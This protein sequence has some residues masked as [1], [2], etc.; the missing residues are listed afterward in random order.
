M[1]AKKNYKVLLQSAVF[2]RLHSNAVKFIVPIKTR[3]GSLQC[4][5]SSFKIGLQAYYS[6][7]NDNMNRIAVPT[8]AIRNSERKCCNDCVHGSSTT[9]QNTHFQCIRKEET[10]LNLNLV[11]GVQR[12]INWFWKQDRRKRVRRKRVTLFWQ[13]INIR[14]SL[15]TSTKMCCIISRQ[16]YTY[17]S[18]AYIFRC[19]SFSD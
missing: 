9:V 17:T 15:E 18:H 1:M 4:I 14:D 16:T 6:L 7:I 3:G 2:H 13:Y 8:V 11:S 5:Q 12:E 19:I 10:M